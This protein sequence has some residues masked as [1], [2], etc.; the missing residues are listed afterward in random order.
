MMQRLHHFVDRFRLLLLSREQHEEPSLASD[1]LRLS[2]CQASPP[3]PPGRGMPIAD[4]I[5]CA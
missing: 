3:S 2:G 5:Y 4:R 1:A